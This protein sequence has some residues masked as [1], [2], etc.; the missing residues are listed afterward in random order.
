MENQHRKITGYRELTQ[1]E[2]D[3]MNEIKAEG[4]R[5]GAL[6]AK[7]AALAPRRPGSV[8]TAP[9]ASI[10]EAAKGLDAALTLA[11]TG[12]T[13]VDGLALDADGAV[14]TDPRWCAIAQTH[15]QEGLMALT[16]AVARPSFF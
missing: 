4:I 3:L 16:R 2:I 14:W 1:A 10:A 7:V 9:A 8:Q 5:L 15:F 12:P 13:T 11:P 6:S